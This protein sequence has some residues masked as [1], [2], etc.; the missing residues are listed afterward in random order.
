MR[1]GFRFYSNFTGEVIEVGKR[2]KLSSLLLSIAIAKGSPKLREQ[3][4]AIVK[5][6]EALMADNGNASAIFGLIGLFTAE[7]ERLDVR[8]RKAGTAKQQAVCRSRYREFASIVRNAC[9]NAIA[10]ADPAEMLA[11]QSVIAPSAFI[12]HED[13]TMPVMLALSIDPE[14][15]ALP[16]AWYVGQQ[17]LSIEYAARTAKGDFGPYKG[18]PYA[19]VHAVDYDTAY[20]VGYYAGLEKDVNALATGMAG[21][22]NDQ[23]FISSYFFR[24]Q[25][26]TLADGTS[27]RRY[28]RALQVC[29]GLRDGFRDA[30]GRAPG[31]HAL[32]LGAPIMIPLLAL[33]LDDVP[34]LSVDSTAPIKNA[35][36][37]KIMLDDPAYMNGSIESIAEDMLTK[38]FRWTHQCVFCKDFLKKH[39][40]RYDDAI[41]YHREVMKGRDVRKDDLADKN[42]IGRF[43]PFLYDLSALSGDDFRKELHIAR[44]GHNH[45][46]MIDLTKRLDE[47]RGS[48]KKLREFALRVCADY[49]EVAA[50]EFPAYARQIDECLR[51]IALAKGTTRSRDPLKKEAGM[52][53]SELGGIAHGPGSA[54]IGLEKTAIVA[55]V[56]AF[57]QKKPSE[58]AALAALSAAAWR[59]MDTA[60]SAARHLV[61]PVL[62]LRHAAVSGGLKTDAVI[63]AMR[64]E[65][66]ILEAL[67]MNGAF[68][69]T[70]GG[71]K[72]DASVAYRKEAARSVAAFAA[73]RERLLEFAEGLDGDTANV[74]VDYPAWE[75]KQKAIAAG[76][77]PDWMRDALD[78]EGFGKEDRARYAEWFVKY[79][80]KRVKPQKL[81]YLFRISYYELRKA[82]GLS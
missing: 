54:V 34:A 11:A 53:R 63:S 21:F 4:K 76:K 44:I 42:G 5:G 71:S 48:K 15:L 41:R 55:A 77:M 66:D 52:T 70:P 79:Y 33:A 19:T 61:P 32:G 80:R 16:K 72:A 36:M 50:K 58:R 6:G 56:G 81:S 17:L 13:Y 47:R 31:F 9:V 37:G 73:L 78:A 65:T 22:M 12:C 8:W 3:A 67:A 25:E 75:E 45:A 30:T 46:V 28:L 49:R 69:A 57:A 82:E 14:R 20:D 18:T 62:G 40:F 24:G 2:M 1:R 59:A 10:D 39:P 43:L 64:N 51:F 74:I 27:P 68:L 26:I 23:S 29:I 35:N 38:G 60:A 7:A